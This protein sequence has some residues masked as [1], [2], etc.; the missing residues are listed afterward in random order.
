MLDLS[1]GKCV[2]DHSKRVA[3]EQTKKVFECFYILA[4][5]LGE[6]LDAFF[7]ETRYC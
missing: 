6:G 7:H 3:D 1:V 2:H 5:R 4:S